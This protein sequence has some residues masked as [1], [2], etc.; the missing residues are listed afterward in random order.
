MNFF[1]LLRM[2][3]WA[4][5]PPSKSRVIL[6]LCVVIFCLILYAVEQWIGWPDA[7][8]PAGGVRRGVPLM[9]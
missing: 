3:R 9:R 8:T 4:Q 6:V 7:L 1:W 5:H 2:K